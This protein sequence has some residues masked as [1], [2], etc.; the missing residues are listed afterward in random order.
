MAFFIPIQWQS[1]K[2][3][4]QVRYHLKAECIA[5]V[6]NYIGAKS[7]GN[8]INYHGKSEAQRQNNQ[9]VSVISGQHFV[10]YELHVEGQYKNKDLDDQGK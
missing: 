3:P 10:Y 8:L 4:E 6:Q 7:S 2:M 1:Q 9:Q 5:D